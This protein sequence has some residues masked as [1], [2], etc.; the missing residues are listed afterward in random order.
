LENSGVGEGDLFLFFGL[1]KRAT[2]EGDSDVFI[3]GANPQHVI[4]GWLQVQD[5]HRIEQGGPLPVRL[6][7]AG[8]HPHI[9][10]RDHYK[11][12]CI[13]V[14]SPNLSFREKTAG[15]G[16]FDKYS[17]DLRLTQQGEH[18]PSFWKLPDF[19]GDAGLT[20]HGPG[21]KT[22]LALW[23]RHDGHIFGQSVGRG[24]EFVMKTDGFAKQTSTWLES[25]FRN[26]KKAN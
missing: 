10:F 15:A 5:K 18:R 14:G 25:I 6:K 11:N 3:R 17:D 2:R 20:Y 1:F 4:W 26:A 12:N 16:I 21:R 23:K 7:S 9:D 24:Q 19:F 13:Y 8:H 22:D